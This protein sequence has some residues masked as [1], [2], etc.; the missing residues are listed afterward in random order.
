MTTFLSFNK[1]RKKEDLNPT[2][3]GYR[4]IV[5]TICS[6]PERLRNITF[7]YM[8]P[9]DLYAHILMDNP[10]VNMTKVFYDYLV[11]LRDNIENIKKQRHGHLLITA[12]GL[13]A[14]E[15][16]DSLARRSHLVDISTEK[17]IFFEYAC[18]DCPFLIILLAS[19]QNNDGETLEKYIE[20]YECITAECAFDIFEALIKYAFDF[21]RISIITNIVNAFSPL[22][23]ADEMFEK[24]NSSLSKLMNYFIENYNTL[25][26]NNMINEPV[27]LV[28]LVEL[29]ELNFPQLYKYY[30]INWTGYAY[31]L[32]KDDNVSELMKLSNNLEEPYMA[33]DYEVVIYALTKKKDGCLAVLFNGFKWNDRRDDADKARLSDLSKSDLE[34]MVYYLVQ[35]VDN[36]QSNIEKGFDPSFVG[37]ANKFIKQTQSGV[38]EVY[39]RYEKRFHMNVYLRSIK[40]RQIVMMK[41]CDNMN[42]N[43]NNVFQSIF[44]DME[45]KH[46]FNE[47][48]SKIMISKLNKALKGIDKYHQ[49]HNNIPALVHQYSDV[50]G[51]IFHQNQFDDPDVKIV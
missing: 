38:W 22:F 16:W 50:S 32:V 7:S 3:A 11:Y 21:R 39:D 42:E 23:M 1:E 29:F 25:N 45:E 33:L 51:M 34:K 26:F 14:N 4:H 48:V 10:K 43:P 8:Q 20:F 6:M 18:W 47:N 5:S 41:W 28:K 2:P 44:N 31:Y 15:N 30:Q 24:V 19:I 13:N 40:A 35:N 37:F 12:F 36:Q 46:T 27:D 17:G 9:N 49:S